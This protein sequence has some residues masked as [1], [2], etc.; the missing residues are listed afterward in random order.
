M[1]RGHQFAQC[2]L[3]HS[4]QGEQETVHIH[5]RWTTVY[6]HG[7][8]GSRYS[9]PWLLRVL[10]ADGSQPSPS[11]HLPFRE[12]S[13]HGK[14]CVLLQSCKAHLIYFD[15]GHLCWALPVGL[16]KSLRHLDCCSAAAF[17]Q[18]CFPHSLKDVPEA[19]CSPVN[20]LCA[21]L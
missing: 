11:K 6:V 8:S 21:Y 17:A 2:V 9:L 12:G 5:V 10:T 14:G 13:I 1:L 18:S 4:N 3:F 20:L 15:P 16:A 7:P 19:D